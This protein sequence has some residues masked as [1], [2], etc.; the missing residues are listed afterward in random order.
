MAMFNVHLSLHLKNNKDYLE[1][2]HDVFDTLISTQKGLYA[3][4][5]SNS[6]FQIIS[7][8]I[9]IVNDKENLGLAEKQIGLSFLVHC[10]KE[11]PEIIEGMGGQSGFADSIIRALKHGCKDSRSTA[12]RTTSLYLM[13]NLLQYFAMEKNKIAPVIYKALTFILIDGYRNT[14]LREEMLKNFISLFKKYQ[15]IPI[16]IL[17]DPFLKQINLLLHKGDAETDRSTSQV[18]APNSAPYAL[19]TTDFEL[20]TCIATHKKLT[21][22]IAVPLLEIACEVALK[23]ILFTRAALKLALLVL[24]RFSGNREVATS[25]EVIINN[26]LKT[27]AEQDELKVDLYAELVDTTRLKRRVALAQ[28]PLTRQRSLT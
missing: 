20:F 18:L 28:G 25:Y 12:Y 22:S 4:V 15:H 1:V 21:A 5:D 17:C 26:L 10:W 8:T 6:L 13:F 27:V 7:H 23:H 9:S 19:N 16:A 2:V 11:M 24:T 14:E 3:M